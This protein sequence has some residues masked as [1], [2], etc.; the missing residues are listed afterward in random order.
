MRSIHHPPSITHNLAALDAFSAKERDVETGLSYFGA[1]YYSSELSIWLSV[2]PMS[3]KYPSTSPYAYCR[4]NPVILIDQSGMDDSPIFSTEG[5]LLG[6]D[7]DGWSGTPVV[8]EESQFHQGMDRKAGTKDEIGTS[9]DEYGK[10][11]SISEKDWNTIESHGG[12]RL[13]PSIRNKS[14]ETVYFKPETNIGDYENGGSYPLEAG[15]DLYMK[16]DGVAAPHLRKNQVFKVPDGSRV[17]ISN[18]TISYQSD[19]I[20]SKA[21]MM[22]KGGWKGN[23]W[24]SFRTTGIYINGNISYPIRKEDHS[25]DALYSKSKK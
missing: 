2:D 8:M 6:T 20:K 25:W 23:L 24:H 14:S 3:G 11:I 15:K 16:I 19:N 22:I 10:G 18:T 17:T 13:N 1:R 21:A 7:K 5:K 12:K 4:N 9:L